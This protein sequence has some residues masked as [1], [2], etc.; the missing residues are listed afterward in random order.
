[1]QLRRHF[2]GSKGGEIR[3]TCS[4]FAWLTRFGEKVEF[5]RA[6]VSAFVAEETVFIDVHMVRRMQA[7]YRVGYDRKVRVPAE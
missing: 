5:V 1:M 3:G 7:A 4:I 6:S 2:I